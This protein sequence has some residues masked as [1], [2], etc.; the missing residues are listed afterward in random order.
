MQVAW[1]MQIL[2]PPKFRRPFL[3]SPL[4]KTYMSHIDSKGGEGIQL[5][6]QSMYSGE[7]QVKNQTCHK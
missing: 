3:P 1:A 4:G 6:I 7:I 2:V 5:S